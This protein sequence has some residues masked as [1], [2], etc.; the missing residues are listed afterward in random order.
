MIPLPSWAIKAVPFLLA[1]LALLAA[2]V[3]IHHRGEKAG[4]AKVTTKVEQQH[5]ARIVEARA[6]ERAATAAAASTGSAALARADAA[7]A[8]LKISEEEMR[9]AIDT[10]P[11]AVPGADLPPA[12]AGV[13][14]ASVNAL[15]DR[16]NRAADT[17]DAAGRADPH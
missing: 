17:A 2:I 4:A 15:V 12:P 7:I 11:P 13:L 16:A 3:T 1:A 8:A 6:D 14:A 10:I 5:A 9:H